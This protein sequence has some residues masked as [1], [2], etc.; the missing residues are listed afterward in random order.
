MAAILE[1]A[2]W[3]EIEEAVLEQ[4]GEGKAHVTE[5]SGE[6]KHR[7]EMPSLVGRNE[8]DW[9]GRPTLVYRDNSDQQTSRAVAVAV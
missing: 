8:G 5:L 6:R 7:A 1:A 9:T 2:R 4:V 3:H